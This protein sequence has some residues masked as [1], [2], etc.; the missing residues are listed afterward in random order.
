MPSF[1]PLFLQSNGQPVEYKGQMIHMADRLPV[2]H[3]QK[4]RVT[5]E[6]SNSEWDQGIYFAT[7]GAF[8]INGQTVKKAL[9]LWKNTA[10]HEVIIRVKSKKRGM[11]NQEC[12]GCW[13]WCCSLVA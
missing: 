5:F 12:M 9:L 13:G 3:S 1:E 8:E 7:D 4:I 2:T 10:P 11:F 6:S